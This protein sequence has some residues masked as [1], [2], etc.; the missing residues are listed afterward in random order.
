MEDLQRP[1]RVH[2]STSVL[3][4]GALFIAAGIA[5]GVLLLAAATWS[6]IYRHPDPVQFP[7]LVVLGAASAVATVGFGDAIVKAAAPIIPPTSIPSPRAEFRAVVSLLVGIAAVV[8]CYPLGAVLGPAAF[9]VGRSAVRRIGQATVAVNG[10]GTAR[11]GMMLGALIS[12]T[13]LLWIVADVA[14]IFMSG[15]PFYAPD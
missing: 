13:Y 4:F 12:A 9:L 15:Q 6:L 8:L 7:I 2:A 1:L 11:T 3:M 14:M 5:E 10:A